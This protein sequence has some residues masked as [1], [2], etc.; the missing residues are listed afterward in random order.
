M[1][2][3]SIVS[4]RR[5]LSG[6]LSLLKKEGLS[7]VANQTSS[8]K[9]FDAT[10]VEPLPG[11]DIISPLVWRRT[12]KMDNPLKSLYNNPVLFPERVSAEELI[13]YDTETTGLSTGA[14]TIPFLIGLGKITDKSFYI[15]QY[16]LVDYPGETE[17]LLALKKDFPENHFYISY[18]GKSY[19]SHL[20][21]SR[22]LMNR[23]ECRR[24]LEIDLLYISRR[25]W[26]R[27]LDNCRLST[28]EEEIL[29]VI[30]E[31][32]IPGS[33]IPDVWFD[34]LK[35]GGKKQLELVFS[36]NLQDIYSLA[37]LLEEINYITEE[38]PT[39][40]N[41]DSYNLGKLF[42]Q[43][44][45]DKEIKKGIKVL[46]REYLKGS[47]ESGQYLSLYYKRSGNWE[48]AL[49]IWE[50]MNVKGVNLF[51]VLEIAKYFEHKKKEP[52]KALVVLNRLLKSPYSPS[53]EIGEKLLYRKK[54][55]LRKINN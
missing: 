31:G 37:L 48:K 33:E 22:Y 21:N 51:S 52:L 29:N 16:F 27:K 36:H 10:T 50:E 25:L 55:L 34:F 19:D 28:I 35:T 14:G 15:I 1:A 13:F 43:N 30:R 17:L 40:K 47:Y 7:K 49:S 54:R 5:S 18:N 4:K 12:V 44:G 3:G 32:D 20:I 2:E 53:G 24:G 23:I 6:R 11:W 38:Y 9:R 42:L 8:T 26:K 39:D 45:N 46:E 41:Y